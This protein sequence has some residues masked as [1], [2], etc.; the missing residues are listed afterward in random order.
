MEAIRKLRIKVMQEMENHEFRSLLVT[1]S[2]PGEGKT[3]IA[4]NLALAFARQG[5]SVVLVDCDLRNPSVA[6]TMGEKNKYPGMTA[7]LQKKET[8][9]NA[10]VTV[11]V[12]RGS[13]RILYGG[14]PDKSAVHYMGTERMAKVV[15][16]LEENADIVIF[17]TAPSDFMADAAMLAKYVDAALYVVRC[18]HAP[19]A[20][21]RNGVSALAESNAKILGYVFNGDTSQKGSGYGY[22]YGYGSYGSYGR[23]GSYGTRK[24]E[25]LSGR[26]IKD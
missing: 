3:T 13:L 9:E 18:D 25:D 1:S 24:K 23:Y 20:R 5:K 7:V 12:E 6:E 17:D 14:A 4:V 10:L 16:N 11:E 8:L 22:G 21:I 19:R 15:R 26:V 2:I